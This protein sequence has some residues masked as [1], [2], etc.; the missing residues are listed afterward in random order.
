ML[1]YWTLFLFFAAGSVATSGREWSTHRRNPL[2]I[3]G[4]VV[5][6]LAIG[7]RY[8][9]GADWFN[10]VYYVD[11]ARRLPLGE[12]LR[13]SDPGYQ[14][15]NWV[16]Y[17]F[18]LDVWFVN[19]V[20][21]SVFTWG[22]YQLC[23]SQPLPWVAASVAIPYLVIVVGM[24][25]TRQAVAL[26]IMMA[27]LAQVT[28][29]ASTVRFAVYAAFAAAFHAT[30]VLLFPLVALSRRTNRITN[31]LMVLAASY[32]L[33]SAF[34]AEN[35]DRYLQSYVQRGYSSQGAGI[36]VV[37]NFVAALVFWTTSKRV[38][39]TDEER[40]L[41]RNFSLASVAMLVAFFLSPSS[42]AV[43]RMALYLLPLQVVALARL[44]LFG[45]NASSGT[46]IV[47]GY[48]GLVEFVWLNFAQHAQ[49]WLPY[50][51]YPF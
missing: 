36:R 22:L 16:A 28:R 37:M 51:L 11:Q 44:P 6:A 7:L 48:M 21:G 42:T 5:V 46:M 1:V 41:W 32:F 27:G 26:G 43:D 4:M 12:L 9:V 34:L 31:F 14:F 10:Y 17:V 19:L 50:Q 18:D 30:A 2:L 39:F 40:A 8:R 23:K 15:V 25:Y 49:Y 13:L 47:V 45:Q 35:V 24:G 29:G 3:V 33:Y 38:G 20:A